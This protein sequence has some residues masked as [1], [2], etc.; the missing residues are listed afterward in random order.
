M[1]KELTVSNFETEVTKSAK[2]V[3]VKFWA[4]WCGPCRSFAPIFEEVA[5]ETEGLSYG[6]INV[7]EQNKLAMEYQVN[8]I[9]TV[10]LF[11]DGEVV[12][13][14]EGILTKEMVL[15]FLKQS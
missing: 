5:K 2:P 7:D 3:L 1:I 15:S 8:L 4:G 9:P 6:S 10:I 14:T 11:K 13:R 12:A